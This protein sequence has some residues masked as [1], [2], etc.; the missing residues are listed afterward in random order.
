L[1]TDKYIR[2]AIADG[3]GAGRGY[4]IG[5]ENSCYLA[6]VGNQT[7]ITRNAPFVAATGISKASLDGMNYPERPLAEV[8][9]PTL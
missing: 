2:R 9:P 8:V 4:P 6:R 5:P 1:L 7:I 3:Q